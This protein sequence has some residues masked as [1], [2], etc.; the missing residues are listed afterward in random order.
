MD[1]NAVMTRRVLSVR[2]DDSLDH[3]IRM[4]LDNGISGLPVLDDDGRPVGMLTEGDLL[5]RA[6]TQTE[7]RRSRWLDF[8]LG[9]DRL[10]A[11]YVRTHSRRVKDVMTPRVY[12]V[13][14]ETPLEEVVALMERRH[15]K[16]LPVLQDGRLIG[17]VSRAN[18][19]QAL[20]SVARELPQVAIADEQIRNRLWDELAARDWAEINLLNIVVHDGVVHLYGMVTGSREADALRTAAENIPGVKAVHNQLVWCEP[21]SGSIVDLADERTEPPA[22][23]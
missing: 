23:Q 10:A 18:L 16:R 20:A 21:L 22:A 7:R 3:A 5:R 1:A 15:I 6:E 12:T 14:P 4:M 2:P 13:T 9:P 8:L 11:D 19:V 17:I